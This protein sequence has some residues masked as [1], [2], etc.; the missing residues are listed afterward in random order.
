MIASRFDTDIKRHGII[1]TR[2]TGFT[3]HVLLNPDNKPLHEIWLRMVELTGFLLNL[4]DFSS[5]EKS[6][7]TKNTIWH[8]I[9]LSQIHPCS[10]L[11]VMRIVELEWME[12]IESLSVQELSSIFKESLK[13]DGYEDFRWAIY[14]LKMK[15]SPFVPLEDLFKYRDIMPMEVSEFVI[16]H[17]C[18]DLNQVDMEKRFV[19]SV[20]AQLHH[21]EKLPYFKTY[22]KPKLVKSY[23][24]IEKQH[25]KIPVEQRRR[26]GDYIPGR[27]GRV[28]V[29]KSDVQRRVERLEELWNKMHRYELF[30]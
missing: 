29:E 7:I 6:K 25:N 1:R 27:W 5:I 24:K 22:I 26:Y 19:N 8:F 10:I 2:M 20:L 30:N 12:Q 3:Q 13:E 23:N 14:V 17:L 4:D 9:N 28:C 11:R 15:K 16:E 21:L 18:K